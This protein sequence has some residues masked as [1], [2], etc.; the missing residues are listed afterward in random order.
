MNSDYLEEQQSIS[1]KL[2]AKVKSKPYFRAKDIDNK[3]GFY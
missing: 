2:P 1:N 3:N